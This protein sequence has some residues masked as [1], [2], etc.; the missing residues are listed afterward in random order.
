MLIAVLKTAD[1]A[2]SADLHPD[3]S[4]L[5][6]LQSILVNVM[7]RHLASMLINLPKKEMIGSVYPTT[8]T[9]RHEPPLPSAHPGDPS[10][11]TL[12]WL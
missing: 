1:F 2:T 3:A 12:H 11:S 7:Q 4:P 5:T 6:D 10:E 9:A 8:G